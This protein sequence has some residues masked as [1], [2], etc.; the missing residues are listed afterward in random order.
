MSTFTQ[1][2]AKLQTHP[3]PEASKI[4]GSKHRWVDPGF[5][6]YLDYDNKDE[7]VVVESGYL[8]DGAT[9]PKILHWLIR[10][11]GKHGQCA[12]LHDKLCETWR[13]NLRTLT[14]K[15]VDEIFYE[16]MRVAGVNVFR[17]LAIQIGVDV[18]RWWS[19]PTGPSDATVKTAL[20]LEYNKK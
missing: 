1:F 17:R 12:V 15:E 16:S 18:Y 7:F 20:T 10:P 19:E 14:R 6:Y 4:L 8:S 5:V 9:V 13:T 11:W 2:T 3:A